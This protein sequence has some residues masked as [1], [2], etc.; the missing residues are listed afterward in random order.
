MENQKNFSKTE[1]SKFDG[2]NGQPAYVA[3]K[4]K[5]YDV[6]E[7]TQWL[8]GDHLGHA[9]GMDLSEAMDIAPHGGDVMDRMKVVGTYTET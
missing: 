8:D 9:A 3:Y 4:G 5:V 7:S 2:K 1:L 6:T